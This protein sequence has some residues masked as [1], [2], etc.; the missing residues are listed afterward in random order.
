MVIFQECKFLL[1]N[2]DRCPIW[3]VQLYGD[4]NY[5]SQD[6]LSHLNLRHAFDLDTYTNYELDDDAILA[7]VL[8][9]SMNNY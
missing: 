2:S 6:L 4:P 8:A 7:Q 5:V 3:V 9:Q 1:N